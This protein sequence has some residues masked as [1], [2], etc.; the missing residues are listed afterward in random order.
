MIDPVTL[1]ALGAALDAASLRQQAGATN[2]ANANTTGYAP[3]RVRFEE[4][5]PSA[6]AALQRNGRLSQR[7]LAEPRLAAVAESNRVP[8]GANGVAIDQEVAGLA[9]NALHYQ[10]L[11]KSLNGQYALIESALGDG[12]R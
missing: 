1:S 12:R 7:D 2:I 4:L 9:R 5:M 3:V 10:A 11:V 8:Y 6:T